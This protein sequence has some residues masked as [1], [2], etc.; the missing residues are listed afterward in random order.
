MLLIFK[1]KSVN[2]RTA[3]STRFTG[4]H[5]PNAMFYK[6]SIIIYNL[7]AIG[8]GTCVN[9]AWSYKNSAF[10]EIVDGPLH[11]HTIHSIY[12]PHTHTYNIHILQHP[13]PL[14]RTLFYLSKLRRNRPLRNSERDP[15]SN[16]AQPAKRRDRAEE[17]PALRIE[18]Q[19][20]YGAAEHG[21]A[22]SE[23]AH[24]EGV[25]GCGDGGEC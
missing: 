23:E 24:G 6:V 20:V 16:Q 7:Y 3:Q 8:Q 25:A 22:G 5:W 21:H 4:N 2:L 14:P 11:Y 15:S 1:Q 10:R 19:Q 13:Y 12:N 9:V 17:L 18:D